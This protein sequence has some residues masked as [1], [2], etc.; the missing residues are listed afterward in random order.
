MWTY[1]HGFEGDIWQH[2]VIA[3]SGL[4]SAGTIYFAHDQSTEGV[5]HLHRPPRPG[6]SRDANGEVEVQDRQLRPAVLPG[7]R[8]ERHPLLRRSERLCLRLR[9]QGG[10][11]GQARA[12]PGAGA[13]LFVQQHQEWTRPVRRQL[14]GSVPGITA[15]PV[16]SADSNT[17]YI[18]STAGLRPSTSGTPERCRVTNPSARPARPAPIRWTFAT[19][20]KVDQTPALGRDGTLYVP[21]MNG[22]QKRLYA[23]KPEWTLEMV[24]G[25]FDTGSET[26]AFPVVGG[27]GT[28]Y[29]GMATPS[30]R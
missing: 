23:V 24:F 8:P 10:L 22:G 7:D 30:T 18:G 6:L 19:I 21:A 4:P 13:E 16:I 29:V 25:P 9:G 27:D 17:L 20:G 26:S 14:V 1:N 28:V 11:Y 5:G 3:P 12:S 15:S 2:P